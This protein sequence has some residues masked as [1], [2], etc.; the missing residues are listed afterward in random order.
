FGRTGTN[1]LPMFEQGAAGIDKLQKKARKLGLTMSTEDAAAA[2]EFTDVMDSLG[3]SLKTAA[4]RAGAALGP[5]LS[6]LGEKFTK[7]SISFGK[8]I[9]DN[10]EAVVETAKTIAKIAA[11][12]LG[13]MALGKTIAIAAGVIG[14]LATAFKLV[15]G[16]ILA[17]T[18]AVKFL[19]ASPMVLLASIAAVV[20]ASMVDWGAILGS[21]KTKLS[22]L[23]DGLIDFS[24]ET[25]KNAEQIT[26]ENQA[27]EQKAHRLDELRTKQKLTND[28][29]AEAAL[30]ASDLKSAYPEL[31][32]AIDQ[33][34]S[35]ASSTT[36]ALGK[37]NAEYKKALLEAKKAE[38]AEE[39][40]KNWQFKAGLGTA[41]MARRDTT[42]M[43]REK[44]ADVNAKA[45]T[46][47]VLWSGVERESWRRDY[48]EQ[49]D[50]YMAAL[51]NETK[52]KAGLAKSNLHI[53]N[54][55]NTIAELE[56]IVAQ[57]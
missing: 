43:T 46:D 27:M 10:R 25:R 55:Q 3:K 15:R 17:V 13:L 21:L 1:L 36:A 56:T 33:I 34:G 18:V 26:A 35:S 9:S 8:W 22:G 11:I 30:L 20:I 16:A 45:M 49:Y 53:L 40:D 6:S 54:L 14:G 41:D 4:F 38:L 39:K 12:G 19:A 24:A 51:Q 29:M 48:R 2:E 28:E 52:N 50:K 23:T 42:G 44:Y 32:D 7:A 47:E 37:M 5:A 57:G 31:A